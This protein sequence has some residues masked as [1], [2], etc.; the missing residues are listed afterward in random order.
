MAFI[1]PDELRSVLYSYQINEITE[2]DNSIALMAIDS[3]VSEVKSYLNPSAQRKWND[4]RLQ[5]DVTKIFNQTGAER[6]ALILEICK[7]IAAYRICRLSNVDVIYENVRERYRDA[8]DWL[9]KVASGEITPNLPV[10]DKDD[11]NQSTNKNELF[12]YGSRRKFRQ[13]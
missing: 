1:T 2:E 13:E 11:D 3:A 9:T 4:G 6:D 12:R 7:D 10:I 5:F 8:I